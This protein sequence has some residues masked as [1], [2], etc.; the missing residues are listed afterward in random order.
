MSDVGQIERKA[1]NRVVKLFGERLGYEYL[2]ELGVS[3]GHLEHRGRPARAEPALH[4][5]TTTT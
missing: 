5:A 3:R 4:A 2:G 1:Q